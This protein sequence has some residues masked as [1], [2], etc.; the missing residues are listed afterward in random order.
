MGEFSRP[1]RS[2]V[3]IRR[4]FHRQVGQFAQK[5]WLWPDLVGLEGPESEMWSLR[6]RF[7]DRGGSFSYISPAA[8][9]PPKHPLIGPAR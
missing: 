4:P 5:L 1:C 7:R 2:A 3:R 8:L 9:V 6:G